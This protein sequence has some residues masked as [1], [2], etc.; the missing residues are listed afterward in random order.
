MKVTVVDEALRE[1]PPEK[2]FAR[3]QSRKD[4]VYLS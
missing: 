2:S 4:T 1:P 3:R